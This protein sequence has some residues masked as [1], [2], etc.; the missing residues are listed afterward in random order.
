MVQS[1]N[2]HFS[3][4][5]FT[6]LVHSAHIYRGFLPHPLAPAAPPNLPAIN[7][8]PTGLQLTGK[9]IWFDLLTD[10]LA[11]AVKKFYGP[12]FRLDVQ[13]HRP[14]SPRAI[15]ASI[16]VGN[17]QM[18]RRN[19]PAQRQA[20]KSGPTNRWLT[21][22]SVPDAAAAARCTRK[23]MAARSSRARPRCRRVARARHPARSAG[24]LFGE[25]EVRLG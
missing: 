3:V 24:A 25:L 13:R 11:G 6:R 16:S 22:I 1:M 4:G 9:L 5:S 10:S 15:L 7:Q 19:L 20:A 8:A 17:E 18:N 21:F 23:A 12:V 14:T 2:V